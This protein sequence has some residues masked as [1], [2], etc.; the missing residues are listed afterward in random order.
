[1]EEAVY[2]HPVPVLTYIAKVF[3][4]PE[5]DILKKCRKEEIV[6]ARQFYMFILSKAKGLGPVKTARSIVRD[7]KGMNH[8]TVIH[9]CK[10]V[11][12]HIDTE[13]LYREKANKILDAY[14]TE[15]IFIL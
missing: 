2:T 4:V 6:N 13:K 14:R 12:N 7:G 1:M 15:K 9:A 8:A 10:T 11:M 3:E 5:E